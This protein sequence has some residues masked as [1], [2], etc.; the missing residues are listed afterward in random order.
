MKN[1]D[2]FDVFL[3]YILQKDENNIADE[4]FTDNILRNLPVEPS[5]RRNLIIY[6]ACTV[7][8]LIFIISSGYK[9]L[10]LSLIDIFSNGFHLIKPSL[11][12]LVVVSIFIGVSL[13]LARMEYDK[14]IV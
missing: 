9:S 7:S 13:C 10:L 12:S 6:L 2:N 4:G 3:K 14:N 11:I 1:I 5:L 8:G